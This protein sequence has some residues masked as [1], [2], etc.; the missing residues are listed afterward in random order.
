MACKK[1]LCLNMFTVSNIID[2]YNDSDAYSDLR[3]ADAVQ[4]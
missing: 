3:S 4:M 2:C 1:K